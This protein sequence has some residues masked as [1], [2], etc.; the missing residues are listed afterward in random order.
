M[1]PRTPA[2]PSATADARRFQDAIRARPAAGKP[3]STNWARPVQYDE[4]GFPIPP[5]VPSFADRV[6]R[7]LFSD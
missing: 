7:I 3:R 2:R 5:A 1:E 6:R 4:S